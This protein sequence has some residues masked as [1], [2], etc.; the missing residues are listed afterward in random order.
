MATMTISDLPACRALDYSAMRSIRGAAGEWVFGATA[1]A[2]RAFTGN[3]TS[4]IVNLY[5]TNNFF[6]DQL[7]VQ[8]QTIDIDVVGDNALVNVDAEQD[9]SNRIGG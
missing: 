8:L 2:L 1:D 4:P 3:R 7:N 5:Q 9:A 6:I